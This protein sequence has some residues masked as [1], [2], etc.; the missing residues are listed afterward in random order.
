MMKRA[1]RASVDTRATDKRRR[2]S[3]NSLRI[4]TITVALL[5]STALAL[6]GGAGTA[7]GTTD[8]TGAAAT[9]QQTQTGTT[10]GQLTLSSEQ[11]ERIFDNIAASP[12]PAPDGFMPSVGAQVPAELQLQPMPEQIASEAPQLQ[13]YEV[14]KLEDQV[15]IV[16]PDNRQVV[17]VIRR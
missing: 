15:L 4:G 13:Q 7:A 9:Q 17:E 11:R 3:M 8:A 10:A 14:A 16:D 2:N 5:G 6:A 12:Q 1:L